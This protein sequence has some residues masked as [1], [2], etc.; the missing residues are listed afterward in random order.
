MFHEELKTRAVQ[1]QQRILSS[2][3]VADKRFCSF[4]KNSDTGYKNILG[5][6]HSLVGCTITVQEEIGQLKERKG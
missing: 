6:W 2:V 4:K 5:K 3:N 1:T